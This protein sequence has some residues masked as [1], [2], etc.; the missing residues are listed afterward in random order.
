M[1]CHRIMTTRQEH[2]QWCKHRAHKYV[3]LGQYH[4]A[5]ASMH[6]DLKKHPSTQEHPGIKLGQELLV[7]GLLNTDYLVRE[8]I[9]GFS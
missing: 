5:I 3:E 1:N 4:M 8:Y 6:S 9:D 7:D 2:L